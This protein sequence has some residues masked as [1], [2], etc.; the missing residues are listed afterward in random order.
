MNIT[1]KNRIEDLLEQFTGKRREVNLTKIGGGSINEAFKMNMEDRT[2]FVKCNA[3]SPGPNFFKCEAEGL[4]LLRTTVN[5]PKVWHVEDNSEFSL[6]ILDYVEKT[7]PN[8]RFWENF[9]FSMAKLHSNHSEKY[10]LD[11]DNYMGS[12]PQ[13]NTTETPLSWV[14]F[15]ITKRLMPQ[16]KLAREKNLIGSSESKDFELL[17]NKL[18]N[19]LIEEKPTLVHGDLWSGNFLPSSHSEVVLFDPAVYYGNREV[20]IAMTHLFG[21]FDDVFYESYHNMLPLEGDDIETRLDIYNIYPLLVHVNLFG[22]TYYNGI[23]I[24]MDKLL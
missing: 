4:K 22:K 24:L 23:Q 11:Y 16:V 9:A 19:I 3:K 6:L 20:D 13:Y 21:G 2:F 18:P 14:E 15:F 17:Y 8:N 7:Y 5:S 12:L 10:G 1:I